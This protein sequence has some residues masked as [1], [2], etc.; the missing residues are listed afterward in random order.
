[1]GSLSRRVPSIQ[2]SEISNLSGLAR[3]HSGGAMSFQ[4]TPVRMSEALSLYRAGRLAEAEATSRAVLA[5]DPD[6][7]DALALLGVVAYQR[8]NPADAVRLIGKALYINSNQPK[9]LVNHGVA[10]AMLARHE[11]ALADF[12]RAIALEPIHADAHNFRGLALRDLG[13]EEE[14]LASFCRAIELNAQH[15][16]AYLNYAVILYELGRLDEALAALDH[17]IALRPDYETAHDNRGTVLMALGQPEEALCSYEIAI[18]L[19]PRDPEYRHHKALTM[20]LLGRFAEGWELY[21]YRWH[22]LR[23]TRQRRNFRR[24]LWSGREDLFGKTVL[25]YAEQGYGD[26]IQ[27]CRYASLVAALGATV[28]LE[29]QPPLKS[30]LFSLDGVRQVIGGGE[31]LPDFDYH[32]PLL[33]LPR[34]FRTSLT[35][36]PANAPYLTP[37]ATATA[38]WHTRMTALPGLRVGIVWAGSS[39][40]HDLQARAIDRRRSIPFSKFA[41]LA[42]VPGVSYV[43]LQ[44][45]DAALQSR[46]P[47][48]SLA[49][50]DWTHELGDF[51]D[52][53]ALIEALDLVVAVD[54]AVAHLAGALGKPIWLLNRFDT[55]W[56]WLLNRNDSPWYPTLRQ[57]RQPRPGDWESVLAEVKTALLQYR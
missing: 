40:S 43:S 35:T 33:S 29:V 49:I 48:F 56:R 38:A 11:E 18:R 50:E 46:T 42:G 2:I 44:K 13:R 6:N 24:P 57:F 20:L 17:V 37:S 51:A 36:I 8:G 25:L 1:L 3:A 26:T 31:T 12:E 5:S 41:A 9:M 28:I 16:D 30:L 27:F 14:A 45:G 32:C 22:T 55:C 21:E 47:S 39:R 23:L 7:A 53:A 4:D 10:L 54:T 15:A 52:T 34:A 19:N